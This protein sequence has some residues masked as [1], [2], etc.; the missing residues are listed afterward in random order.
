MHTMRVCLAVALVVATTAVSQ[1]AAA[2]PSTI[3]GRIW[4][5]PAFGTVMGDNPVTSDVPVTVSMTG[6]PLIGSIDVPVPLTAEVTFEDPVGITFGGE[7]IL[8]RIGVELSGAYVRKAAVARGGLKVRGGLL[9]EEQWQ[10]LNLAGFSIPD[11]I[12]VE[13]EIE[14]FAASLGVNYHFI[15]RG[16]LD[17]WAGPMLVWS[18]WSEYD[19]SDA[20]VELSQSIEDLIHG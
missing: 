10:L 11:F 4:F 8:R 6:I 7:L 15:D 3:R 14:N 13:E 19:L 12:F 9:T 20:R 5:Q 2:G 18:A 1:P 17:V 16:R